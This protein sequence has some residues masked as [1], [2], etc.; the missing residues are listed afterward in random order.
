MTIVGAAA[1]TVSEQALAQPAPESATIVV[2]VFRH[3]A[4]KTPIA[5]PAPVGNDPEEQLFYETL[6]RDLE[7]CG[8]FMDTGC[9]RVVD[10]SCNQKKKWCPISGKSGF[11]RCSET[12]ICCETDGPLKLGLHR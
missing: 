5:L 11:L 10:Q 1:V 3:G 12:I 7:I 2:D 9:N 8:W 4:A 6:R